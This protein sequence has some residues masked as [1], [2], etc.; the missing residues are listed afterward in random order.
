MKTFFRPS[1]TNRAPE[2]LAIHARL[3]THHYCR[4]LARPHGI[5]DLRFAA[6]SGGLLMPR[7]I[8]II[9][10]DLHG[11]FVFD[12]QKFYQQREPAFAS[13]RSACPFHRHFIPG[14]GEPLAFVRS[15]REHAI[16]P[17]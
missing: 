14:V 15:S 17:G 3:E 10:M 6:P 9:R 8:I 5:P 7:S 2:F 4:A 16:V 11:E 12:E 1:L 13:D